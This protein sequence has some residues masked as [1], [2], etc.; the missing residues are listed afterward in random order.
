M[1]S[2]LTGA[3]ILK[4]IYEYA[5]LTGTADD[6][7]FLLD[8]NGNATAVKLSISQL[9]GLLKHNYLG[10]IQTVADGVTIGHVDTTNLTEE[11]LL[12]LNS[13]KEFESINPDLL[14]SPWMLLTESYTQTPVSTNQ[15]TITDTVQDFIKEG[16][17][18]KFKQDFPTWESGETYTLGEIVA[19][20]TANGFVYQCTGAGTSDATE[21]VWGEVLKG[22]TNDNT[23]VWSAIEEYAYAIVYSISSNTL[24]V[25]GCPFS[26]NVT[27]IQFCDQRNTV[28]QTIP[29]T[30]ATFQQ[31]DTDVLTKYENDIPLETFNGV[32]IF[33]RTWCKTADTGANKAKV[34]I[35]NGSDSVYDLT[36]GVEII[37]DETFNVSGA[38]VLQAF[39]YF[40]YLQSLRIDVSDAG[41]NLDTTGVRITNVYILR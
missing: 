34:N 15:L 20:S 28:M 24:L 41:S 10:E 35:K 5:T 13:N 1:A 39:A 4:R 30:K 26:F 40:D 16:Y 9:T 21:P 27:E 14:K 36:D 38:N 32:L 37:A 7:E 18:I 2:E 22:T 25:Y 12:K 8:K 11:Y 23:V 33:T 3:V 19:P 17:G 6:F 29:F 31:V